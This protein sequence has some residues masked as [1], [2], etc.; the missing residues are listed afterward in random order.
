MENKQFKQIEPKICTVLFSWSEP[1]KAKQTFVDLQLVCK[2]LWGHTPQYK[3]E[4]GPE[5][6]MCSG[7][8]F[9]FNKSITNKLDHMNLREAIKWQRIGVSALDEEEKKVLGNILSNVY[10]KDE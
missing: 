3:S 10:G 1:F 6:V 8:G 2:A 9:Q 5:G 4:Q 7:Y